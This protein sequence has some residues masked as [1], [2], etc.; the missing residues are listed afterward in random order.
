MS[1]ENND[2]WYIGN[3]VPKN[4][5]WK[6]TSIILSIISVIITSIVLGWGYGT[7]GFKFIP[8]RKF[9][10][11]A[12]KDM[13]SDPNINFCNNDNNFSNN[14][15]LWWSIANKPEDKID[16]QTIC[17]ENVDSMIKNNNYYSNKFDT[18][19]IKKYS[20]INYM[21]AFTDW[22]YNKEKKQY[23]KPNNPKEYLAPVTMIQVIKEDGN[24]N[25]IGLTTSY[26]KDKVK[27]NWGDK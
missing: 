21:F 9:T 27:N 14:K 13:N 22:N 18:E 26:M 11:N 2:K 6:K 20:N 12:Y 5:N 17:L 7:G 24:Y 3:Y 8:L 1:E 23:K 10:Q 16:P 19:V 4:I 15:N 25:I